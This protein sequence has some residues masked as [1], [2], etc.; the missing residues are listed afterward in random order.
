MTSM[1]GQILSTLFNLFN[2]SSLVLNIGILVFCVLFLFYNT[3]W[4]FNGEQIGLYIA[5]TESSFSVLVCMSGMFAKHA[6]VRSGFI[7]F[8]VA[9]A[10]AAISQLVTGIL[11]KTS[12]FFFFRALILGM[13]FQ[14]DL[15]LLF[16]AAVGFLCLLI[17]LV[18]ARQAYKIN[19]PI[20]DN[21]SQL[22]ATYNARDSVPKFYKTDVERQH[23]YYSKTEEDRK[24]NANASKKPSMESSYSGETLGEDQNGHDF[25]DAPISPMKSIKLSSS[26]D[27]NEV[28]LDSEDSEP[29]KSPIGKHQF[30]S[31]VNIDSTNRRLRDDIRYT[32]QLSRRPYK[33]AS[34]S[35]PSIPTLPSTPSSNSR[36]VM[37]STG[38]VLGNRSARLFSRNSDK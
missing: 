7:C 12:T 5:L 19:K 13:G 32:R 25:D 9:V 31:E 37:S 26:S 3:R 6:G 2:L 15:A 38:A 33:A 24:M 34:K 1:R 36:V 20:A 11:M 4:S 30:Y 16:S 14:L 18:C 17:S 8:A 10:L 21:E 27:L 23:S 28:S 29:E 35:S 22:F